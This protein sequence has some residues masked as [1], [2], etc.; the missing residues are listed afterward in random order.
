M[1]RLG[2][3]TLVAAALLTGCAFLAEIYTPPTQSMR[4][5]PDTPMSIATIGGIFA[6]W[7]AI[8][9]MWYFPPTQALLNKYFIQVTAKP[10]AFGVF[11]N[12]ISH[13]GFLHM[14]ANMTAVAVY[15]VSG[16]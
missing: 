7:T 8:F 5:F 11:G 10:Y 16:R 13:Q 14:A 6:L 4:L 2:P 1:R 12:T 3:S 9:C 15:G